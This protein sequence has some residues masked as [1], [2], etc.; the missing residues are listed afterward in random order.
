MS[1]N[2]INHFVLFEVRTKFL[3]IIYKS[4]DFKG[5]KLSMKY[6]GYLINNVGWSLQLLRDFVLVFI[7]VCLYSR[8]H[9]M[10]LI[11]C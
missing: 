8:C 11:F 7:N 10:V 4:I 9:G 3:N 1:L 5:L 6:T 2:S